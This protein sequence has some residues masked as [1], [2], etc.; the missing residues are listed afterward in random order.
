MITKESIDSAIRAHGNWKTRLKQSIENSNFDFDIYKASTDDNCEFGKWLYGDTITDEE[1]KSDY[2]N[3]VKILHADFHKSIKDIVKLIITGKKEDASR[4]YSDLNGK[5]NKISTAL[6][7][8][9]V[10]WEN[11]L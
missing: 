9:L 5:F 6:V 10:E 2:Y 11:T 8:L 3:R 1:K 4:M 7:L